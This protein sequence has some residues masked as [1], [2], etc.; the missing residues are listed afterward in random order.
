MTRNERKR[1]SWE[2][3]LF[4]KGELSARMAAFV[5]LKGKKRKEKKKSKERK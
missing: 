3:T 4:K 2:V 1:S 5:P